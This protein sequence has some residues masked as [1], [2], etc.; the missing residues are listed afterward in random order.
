VSEPELRV[1]PTPVCEACGKPVDPG[2]PDVV[3]AMPAMYLEAGGMT[4]WIEGMGVY[5]HDD[6]FPY[7]SGDYGVFGGS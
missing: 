7:G 2:A 4:E 6:C 3:R 1:R 5:F